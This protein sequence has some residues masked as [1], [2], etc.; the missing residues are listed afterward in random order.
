MRI[1]FNGAMIYFEEDIGK[2]FDLM[3]ECGHKL[4]AHGSP[5]RWGYP[6]SYVHTSQCTM[7][8]CGCKQFKVVKDDEN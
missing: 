4:G 1:E 6:T 3:C 7:W 8:R 5:V 2:V